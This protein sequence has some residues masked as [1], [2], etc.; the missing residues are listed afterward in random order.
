MA[1]GLVKRKRIVLDVAALPGKFR[2][3]VLPPP[4]TVTVAE[5]LV[6][7]P[8]PLQLSVN[9]LL[10]LVSAPVLAVP[11]VGFVPLHAP[12][13][14]HE[15]A[16]LDDQLRFALPP[17]GTL[18]GLALSVTAGAGDAADTVTVTERDV[19]PPAPEQLSEYVRVLPSD[20]VDCEPLVALPPDQAPEAV[21]LVAFVLVQLNVELAPLGRLVGFA[22]NDSVGAGVVAPLLTLTVMPDEVAVLPAASRAVAVSV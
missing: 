21:Q 19:L 1:S 2:P 11:E 5:R 6:E 4:W 8:G 16:S 15:L 3:K 18:V 20:P 17:L 12:L 7:P 10:V 9:V 14:V 13:A 22:V